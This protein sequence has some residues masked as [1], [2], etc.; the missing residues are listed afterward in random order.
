MQ[1]R[2]SKAYYERR[3]KYIADQQQKWDIE[4]KN[5]Q[6][7]EDMENEYHDIVHTKEKT[8]IATSKL[9][10]FVFL[11]IC[12]IAMVFTG[13]ATVQSIEIAKTIGLAPDFTPMVAFLGS[14]VAPVVSILGYYNKSAKE[15]CEGGI[16]HDTAVNVLNNISIDDGNEDTTDNDN[17]DLN[18]VG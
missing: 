11:I 6:A 14:I 5:L 17:D 9:I 1:L 16:V 8:K 12:V 2:K 4:S 15:N 10:L 13:W 7:E 3:A 18:S